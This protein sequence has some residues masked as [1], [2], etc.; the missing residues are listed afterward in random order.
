MLIDFLCA[1]CMSVFLI[2]VL[3][4]NLFTSLLSLQN[5]QVIHT[6]ITTTRKKR[7]NIKGWWSSEML[8]L[9]QVWHRTGYTG[10]GSGVGGVLLQ[11]CN[12][13]LQLKQYKISCTQDNFADPGLCLEI[14][15]SPTAHSFNPLV[16]LK[17]PTLSSRYNSFIH[18]GINR[19]HWPWL[20]HFNW[21]I[22]AYTKQTYSII[23][24]KHT[25]LPDHWIF[26]YLFTNL[27]N[28]SMYCSTTDFPSA[29][30]LYKSILICLKGKKWKYGK[31]IEIW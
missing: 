16:W 2:I 12:R 28:S 15:Y 21:F 17:S 22:H 25:Q 20:N 10:A 4:P 14:D 7:E 26:T 24:C 18:S 3:S 29:R 1:I 13:K 11:P 30:G 23:L 31:G 19:F 5:T 8:N 27:D 9:R 6:T